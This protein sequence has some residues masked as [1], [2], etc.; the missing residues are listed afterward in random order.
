MT[1]AAPTELVSIPSLLEMLFIAAV[2]GAS[3]FGR[4]VLGRRTDLEWTRSTIG[5]V[6]AASV[7]TS[8]F[9]TVIG[10]SLASAIDDATGEFYVVNLLLMP[11]L[12]LAIIVLFDNAR[13]VAAQLALPTLASTLAVAVFCISV[14]LP[15]PLLLTM[16]D[17]PQLSHLDA[18]DAIFNAPSVVGALVFVSIPT[19]VGA[20]LVALVS[21]FI[22]AQREFAIG[23]TLVFAANAPLIALL[24]DAGVSAVIAFAMLTLANVASVTLIHAASP[25]RRGIVMGTALVGGG[26]FLGG[27]AAVDVDA[28]EPSHLF[29]AFVLGVALALLLWRRSRNEDLVIVAQAAVCTIALVGRGLHEIQDV[30]IPGTEWVVVRTILSGAASLASLYVVLVRLRPAANAEPLV[31]TDMW[32]L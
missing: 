7:A 28:G 5:L 30:V 22:G 23:A 29:A 20:A 15:T 17:H 4:R 1:H 12:W 8:V 13:A 31:L 19:L 3:S 26:F 16:L 25:H 9:G 21:N 2:A 24:G 14:Y 11:I 10:A 18:Y 32:S 6:I 27:T